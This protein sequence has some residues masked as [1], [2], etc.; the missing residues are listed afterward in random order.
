MSIFFPGFFLPRF[1]G[2]FFSDFYLK[3]GDEQFTSQIQG[4]ATRMYQLCEGLS[5]GKCLKIPSNQPLSWYIW[6]MA[7][8][9]KLLK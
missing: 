3:D 4:D 1:R 9:W 5:S 6:Y 7:V 8:Y 2:G